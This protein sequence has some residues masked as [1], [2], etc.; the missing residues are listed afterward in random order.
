MASPPTTTSWGYRLIFIFTYAAYIAVYFTRKPFSVTKSTLKTENVHTESEL[1]MIDT[2]FLVAYA[3]GQFMSGPVASVLGSKLGLS[4]AFIGTGVCSWVFGTSP[5]REV[6][7]TAWLVNG[8]FQAFFFPFIMD[9]LRAWFPPSTRGQV[10]GVWTTCQQLGGFA[11]SAF[12]GYVLSTST[13]HDA[14]VWP[15]FLAFGFAGLCFTLLQASPSSGQTTVKTASTASSSRLWE[16]PHLL[17][18][19][20]AY[21]CIKLVR[22]TFLGWL[23]FYLTS[24]LHYSAAESVLLS[25]AFDLAG[26]LGSVLCGYASDAWCGGR[27]ARIV[28]PMCALCGVATLVYPHVAAVGSTPNIAIM[29]AVGLFVAG[30]D[31]MLGG[32]ACAEICERAGVPSASTSATGIVNG[33][34][35]LGAIASGMLPILIKEQFGWNVLFYAMGG[36]AIVGGAVLLPMTS[37]KASVT[38]KDT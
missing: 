29:A 24:V 2:G 31:S 8:L 17:L 7:A 38:K 15:A 34:G 30:P 25:T 6:R 36:L 19:G 5:S 27:S 1:G 9:V 13:W 23:P 14:F 35:S 22:Y 3:V 33:M 26:T 11:T 28:A 16:V 32:A 18:V 37:G 4:F 10:L 20:S 21:F 12:G